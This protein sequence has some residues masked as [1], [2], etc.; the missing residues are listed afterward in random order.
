MN[1]DFI[2]KTNFINSL[3]KVCANIS[4]LKDINNAE[5]FINSNNKQ[6]IHI[7][8]CHNVS[9]NINSKINHLYINN[10]SHV[11]IVLANGVISTIYVSD[12]KK[13]DILNNKGSIPFIECYLVSSLHIN[14]NI[15]YDNNHIWLI[16]TNSIGIHIIKNTYSCLFG[17]KVK[18]LICGTQL[19]N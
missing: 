11:N 4:I 3:K 14:N 1:Y 17:I 5:M 12:S 2:S 18:K 16:I 19:Y 15:K 13:I 8:N 6:T 10:C 9:I 7:I